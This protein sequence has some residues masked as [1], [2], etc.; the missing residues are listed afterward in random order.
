M[1]DITLNI[2]SFHGKYA[3]K[4]TFVL[5]LYV[6]KIWFVTPTNFAFEVLL[7][8]INFLN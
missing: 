2:I 8:F 7:R 6:V 4:E 5:T 3:L 1:S